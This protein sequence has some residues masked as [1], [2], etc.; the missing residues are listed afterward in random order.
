MKAKNLRES[1]VLLAASLPDELRGSRRAQ[2]LDDLLVVL[3]GGLLTSSVTVVF[4]GHPTVT[5]LIHRIALDQSKQ[6]PRII[7]FQLAAFRDEAPEQVNDASVFQKV[8]WVGE[9]VRREAQLRKDLGTMRSEM[10]K[11][12]DAAIFV[13]GRTSRNVARTKGL[14]DEFVAF[15]RAHPKAPTYVL[16]CLDGECGRMIKDAKAGKLADDRN[17]LTPEER[18]ALH[19]REGVDLVASLVLADLRRALA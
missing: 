13:G 7:L 16:G 3:V 6:K 11:L 5:P 19:G 17:G 1:K 4:G 2:D 8:H 10:A 9:G 14:R 18:K 15:S 12:S